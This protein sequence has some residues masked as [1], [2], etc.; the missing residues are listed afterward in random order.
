[1]TKIRYLYLAVALVYWLPGAANAT[2]LPSSS[3]NR[4]VL[5]LPARQRTLQLGFDL[6]ELRPKLLL[7]TYQGT[8]ESADAGMHVW[9]GREWLRLNDADYETGNFLRDGVVVEQMYLIGPGDDVPRLLQYRPVWSEDMHWIQSLHVRDLVNI[10]GQ[11]LRFTR[12]EWHWLARLHDLDLSETRVR[13]RYVERKEVLPEREP[14]ET[15]R[16]LL[17]RL[18]LY[19]ERRPAETDIHS[20]HDPE[21]VE[22]EPWRELPDE[23]KPRETLPL[24]PSTPV[25]PGFVDPA[26]PDPPETDPSPVAPEPDYEPQPLVPEKGAAIPREPQTPTPTPTPPPAE[27]GE[28]R[29]PQDAELPMDD[30]ILPEQPDSDSGLTPEEIEFF[31]L[32]RREFPDLNEPPNLP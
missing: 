4:T 5:L 17:E 24:A 8:V 14:E 7:I 30:G 16:P 23:T 19:R 1:M 10:F 25:E 11:R 31:E 2:P 32:I 9:D 18:R 12:A 26:L 28:E 22:A 29:P 21:D 15:R 20:R 13:Q 27:P 6:L 3:G